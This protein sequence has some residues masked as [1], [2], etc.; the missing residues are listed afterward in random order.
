[1]ISKKLFGTIAAASLMLSSSVAVAQTAAP[2]P[3]P[4]TE[5]SLGNDG[6][7]QFY[8]YGAIHF[9]GGIVIF[10]GIIYLILKQLE[11]D[12]PESP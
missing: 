7:G 3:E 1:M 4:A 8:G 11:K 6:E 2:A 9:L 12:V 5:Q 10:G